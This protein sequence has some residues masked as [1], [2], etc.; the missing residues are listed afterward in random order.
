MSC[1]RDEADLLAW[2]DDPAA[3]AAHVAACPPCARA[4][5]A[6]RRVRA[7]ARATRPSP[8]RRPRSRAAR[9]LQATLPMAAATALVAAIGAGPFLRRRIAVPPAAPVAGLLDA[10]TLFWTSAAGPTLAARAGR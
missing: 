3:G 9:A 6:M 4:V 8:A 5:A 10:T 7:L 1:G 2:L